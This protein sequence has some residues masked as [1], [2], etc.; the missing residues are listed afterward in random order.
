MHAHLHVIS[1]HF[2]ETVAVGGK[3]DS[4]CDVTRRNLN[5][6]LTRHKNGTKM[7]FYEY[8]RVVLAEVV[9]WTCCMCVTASFTVHFGCGFSEYRSETVGDRQ[10]G[11]PFVS[12]LV[13]LRDTVLGL[14]SK[15]NHIA[16]YCW[17][18]HTFI[19]TAYNWSRVTVRRWVTSVLTLIKRPVLCKS[20]CYRSYYILGVPISRSQVQ[21]PS[22]P[23]SDPKAS[24]EL[25]CT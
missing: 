14:L 2:G 15:F 11:G 13:S 10:L 7:A 6:S 18:W 19:N 12:P 21:H 25:A 9:L 22:D 4:E 16:I 3:K 1:S 24:Q 17:Y 23:R 20:P 5:G 8:S